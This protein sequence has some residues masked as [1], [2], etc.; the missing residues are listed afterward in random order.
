M[1]SAAMTMYRPVPSHH[2]Q[3]LRGSG[4]LSGGLHLI[5][6]GWCLFRQVRCASVG[7][8]LVFVS[9]VRKIT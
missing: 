4:S 7:D 5:G 9:G 3:T 6:G 8:G 2:D 1:T